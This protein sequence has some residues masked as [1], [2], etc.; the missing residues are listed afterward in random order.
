MGPAAALTISSELLSHKGDRA[1]RQQLP[2]PDFWDAMG[3]EG[4]SFAL[5]LTA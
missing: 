1:D 2:T 4:G 5:R 3:K